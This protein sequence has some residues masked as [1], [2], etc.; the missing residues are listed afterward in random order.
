ML[1]ITRN[2]QQVHSIRRITRAAPLLLLAAG[3]C[4]LA[5]VTVPAGEEVVAV[6]AIL[7]TDTDVQ[8]ILL[9][10]S[11]EGRDVR[12]VPGAV[13]TVTSGSG[14]TVTFTEAGG[15][16]VRFSPAYFRERPGSVQATCYTSSGTPGR[17]VVPGEVYRLRVETPDGRLI[18]GRTLVPGD[19]AL[20]GLPFT[21]DV[22]R[23]EAAE[24]AL[25]P[26]TT[27]PVSWTP[28][29]SAWSYLAPL[30]IFGLR[31]A[32]AAQ[33]VT[34]D[35]A[36]PLELFG[37]AISERDTA[38]VLPTEFGVFDRFDTDQAVLRV[39][40]TGF[41]AGVVVEMVV[42]AADRNYVNG[43]RGGRFNPSGPVRISS[44]SGDGVGV[45]GSMVPL[46]LR[47]LVLPPASAQRMG[48]LPC[49]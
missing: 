16:C 24:C 43:V 36:D 49:G 2:H 4:T 37:L 3:A 1:P 33:G 45:F 17:W 32:L 9:H 26:A 21:R 39:L 7:R 46:Y 22:G 35:I 23:R 42:A 47:V 38:I 14:R 40:Q 27:L 11:L 48:V 6:E 5:D 13:V 8:E 31:G 12:G 29:D 34:A 10:R 30:R 15:E 44:V 19:F 28:A 41:P 18:Q 25:A 20:R